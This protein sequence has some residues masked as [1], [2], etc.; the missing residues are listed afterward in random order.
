[1]MPLYIAGGLVIAWIIFCA[2][3]PPAAD[4]QPPPAPPELPPD[5]DEP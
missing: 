2:V 1:M 5:W 4:A 3:A